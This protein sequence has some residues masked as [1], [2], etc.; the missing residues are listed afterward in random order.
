MGFF[1]GAARCKSARPRL[2]LGGRSDRPRPRADLAASSTAKDGHAVGSAAN[3]MRHAC[4]WSR[5]AASCSPST[6]PVIP[7]CSPPAGLHQRQSSSS[8][9]F[10]LGRLSGRRRR[11]WLVRPP[12]PNI[13]VVS[14]RTWAVGVVALIWKW[15]WLFRMGHGRA[16]SS[17]SAPSA[18][19]PAREAVAPGAQAGCQD[20]SRH[21]HK[22]TSP[23]TASPV[24][25]SRCRVVGR[26]EMAAVKA[27]ATVSKCIL[28]LQREETREG[29]CNFYDPLDGAARK[30]W[31]RPQVDPHLL[32]HF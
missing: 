9:L 27:A 30:S 11:W 5:S 14:Q 16:R 21:N 1:G 17:G 29:A 6:E 28:E 25:T 31:V 18:G 10:G 3:M 15:S 13:N 19:P 12:T 32:S 7:P 20:R 8:L 2:G 23:R 24:D 22:P 4:S 26:T